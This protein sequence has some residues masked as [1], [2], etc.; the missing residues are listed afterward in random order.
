MPAPDRCLA[1]LPKGVPVAAC[2][3]QTFLPVGAWVSRLPSV[4]NAAS[5]AGSSGCVRRSHRP[6]TS[7]TTNIALIWSARARSDY[8]LS[9][10][11]TI[12][13]R[14]S[15]S[16]RR[17]RMAP[18]LSAI[19]AGSEVPGITAVTRSSPSRYLRKNCAQLLAKSLAQ[20][21]TVLP[22]TARKRRPLPN[23]WAVSTPALIPVPERIVDLHEI[24]LFARDDRFH[25]R[26]IAVES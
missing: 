24:W 20:S 26:K 16:G 13:L 14:W 8:R 25:R 22:R 4:V 11:A 7:A 6:M 5:E 18:R 19:C 2:G 23:G 15:G 1:L 9:R 12:R 17:P 21:G 10:K 3:A